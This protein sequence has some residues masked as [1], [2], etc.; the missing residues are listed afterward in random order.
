MRLV[1]TNLE[2]IVGKIV[3]GDSGLVK[4]GVFSF[5]LFCFFVR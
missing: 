4:H 1:Q 5:S 3:F 2:R